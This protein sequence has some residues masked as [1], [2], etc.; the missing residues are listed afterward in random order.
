M[1]VDPVA[2]DDGV[3]PDPCLRLQVHAGQ[4][5][6]LRVD[7]PRDRFGGLTGA[8]G[9]SARAAGTATAA[10]GE[11]PG[12]EADDERPSHGPTPDPGR[13]PGRD[14]SAAVGT[15]ARARGAGQD[16]SA[17]ALTPASP[18]PGRGARPP[19]GGSRRACGRS[20]LTWPFTVFRV[21]TSS[22]AIWAKR[23]MAGQQAEHP[24]LGRGQVRHR[25]P[26][27]LCVGDELTFAAP[28]P[29]RRARPVAG[30]SRS[31]G[32]RL[33]EPHRR[34]PLVAELQLQVAEGDRGLD[35]QPGERDR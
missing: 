21:T 35:G 3:Q 11:Q 16:P 7:T 20:R 9:G 23:E 19:S 34:R 17:P 18:P 1:P 28:R 32:P 10:G 22:S 6:I 24:E 33:G 25:V 5:G 13:L 31:V 2:Q 29:D 15:L 12:G 4:V 30:S 8:R 27:S 26:V 14:P